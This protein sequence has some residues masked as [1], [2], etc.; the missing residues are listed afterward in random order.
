MHPAI[1]VVALV[2]V[3]ALPVTH[4]QADDVMA[5][6]GARDP[7]TACQQALVRATRQLADGI[8]REI[9]KCV[10]A[11]VRC[12]AAA[13]DPD[14]CCATVAAR[15]RV[16][17]RALTRM[18]RR[19]PA[20]VVTGR[21]AQ[22]PFATILDPTGLGFAAAA[23]T[24]RCLPTATDVTDLATLADCLGQLVATETTRLV[25][26]AESPRAAEALACVDLQRELAILESS[27]A[28]LACSRPQGTPATPRATPRPT[29]TPRPRRTPKSGATATAA[30]SAAAATPT[31]TAAAATPTA[32]ALAPTPVATPVAVCGNGIVEGDEE[33]DGSAYDDTSCL[34]DVCTCD[35]FCDDAGGRLACR[36]DCTIDF[37]HCTAGGCEF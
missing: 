6:A 16:A 20:R 1:A 36:R 24:C 22:V 9:G 11:G 32:T 37:S 31:A 19:F 33:C 2:S 34:E 12:L 21:C 30:P 14:A 28:A 23:D 3:L 7:L 29:R 26:I 8:R 18:E 5:R 17:T 13:S 10:A 15:C 4:A 35:D 25:A 27:D